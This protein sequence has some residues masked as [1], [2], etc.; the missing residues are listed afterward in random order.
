MSSS[1]SDMTPPV[2][3]AIVVLNWN[4]WD[5]TRECLQSLR[6]VTPGCRV[7]LVDNGSTDDSV[8]R[9]RTEFP[10]VEVIENGANLGFTEGNN[11]GIARALD[12]G[13]DYVMLLNNDTI[14]D[15]G[16]L[17]PLLVAIDRHGLGFASPRIFYASDP[18]EL[19]FWG[20]D[21]DWRTG[22][23]YHRNPEDGRVHQ[24]DLVPTLIA[25][26]CCLLAPRDTW[27]Q[28][29]LLDQRFF[30]FWEDAD[31]T[32][33]ATRSGH[34]GAV[35]AESRIWHKVSRS[36][37]RDEPTLG[38]FYFVRNGLLFVAKHA[39]HRPL[40]A[41]RFLYRWVL[42]PTLA[43]ARRREAAWVRIGLLRA[44]GVLAY[45]S[46]SFGAAPRYAVRI[47]ARRR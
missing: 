22:W 9:T 35:V 23:A 17:Q 26:G 21:I 18:D 40:V 16:F 25:T 43:A 30:L 3:V 44:S 27:E 46:R 8:A 41:L 45:L 32:L 33:R 15:P 19:W 47:A 34:K 11:R 7:L 20:G 38:I 4:G 39:P 13:A 5:D 31:W 10:E 29:G 1:C 37:A 28:V 2:E 12:D 6:A 14:V 24:H 42:R 36:F